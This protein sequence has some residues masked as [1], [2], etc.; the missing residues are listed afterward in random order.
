[1]TTT[2]PPAPFTSQ[3]FAARMRRVVAELALTQIDSLDALGRRLVQ[4]L[5]SWHRLK[6]FFQVSGSFLCVR[7]GT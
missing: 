4:N 6:L 5:R 7:G 1:M 3:D 2:Q